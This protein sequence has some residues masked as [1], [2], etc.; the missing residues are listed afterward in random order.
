VEETSPTDKTPAETKGAIQSTTETKPN[1]WNINGLG[2]HQAVTRRSQETKGAGTLLQM[3]QKGDGKGLP[4]SPLTSRHLQ[5]LENSTKEDQCHGSTTITRNGTVLPNC[6]GGHNPNRFYRG[7][8]GDA[9]SHSVQE[10]EPIRICLCCTYSLS[11]KETII[12]TKKK[13]T[14][15]WTIPVVIN[16]AARAISL[17]NSGASGNFMHQDMV[18]KLGLVPQK[19][20]RT[21]PVTDIQGKNLGWIDCAVDL[22]LQAATHTETIQSAVMLIG[23]HGVILG[24]PWL[25][26]HDPSI[27]WSEG[28][29][30]FNSPYC[31]GNC[32]KKN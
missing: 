24:L 28:R 22:T 14:G 27:T 17:L 11:G 2:L 13:N 20:T 25:K 1:Q 16:M 19:T 32:N 4:K 30:K 7:L 12:C 18:D 26:K 23:T 6:P 3:Q 8:N 21:I 31:K 29:I 9:A 15:L 10:K 5:K